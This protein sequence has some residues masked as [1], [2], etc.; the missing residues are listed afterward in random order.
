[1]KKIISIL[2]CISMLWGLCGCGERIPEA[3]YRG[4]DTEASDVELKAAVLCFEPEKTPESYIYLQQPLIF[5]LE[6]ELCDVSGREDDAASVLDGAELVYLDESLLNCPGA[7]ALFSQIEAYT[8]GGCTV[9]VPNAFFDSF[10]RG[11]LGAKSFRRIGGYPENIKLCQCGADL[12]KLGTVVTDFEQLYRQYDGFDRLASCDYGYAMAVGSAVPLVECSEGALYTMNRYG[13][14]LV[15]FTN[16]LLP[17]YYSS[18][19]LTMEKGEQTVTGF[20]ASS[21]SFNMLIYSGLGEYA[22]KQKYGY[23]L[24]KAFGYFGTPSM[25]WELHY[26]EITGIENGALYSFAELA[27]QARQIPSWTIIR[28]SYRWF[29]RT[30]GTSYLLGS[31]AEDGLHFEMDLAENAYSSGTHIAA[32]SAWLSNGCEMDETSYFSDLQLHDLRSYPALADADGDGLTDI[33]SGSKDGNIYFYKGK[34]YTD[35]LHTYEARILCDVN[36]APLNKGPYSAPCMADIDGDGDDDLIWGVLGGDLYAAVCL[37]DMTF[38]APVRLLA[39][40]EGGTGTSGQLLPQTCDLNGD[41]ALDLLLGSDDGNLILINGVP[42][43]ACAQA[44][45]ADHDH[46]EDS[47]YRDMRRDCAAAGLGSWLSPYAADIDADAEYELL[48]GTYDGYIYSFEAAYSDEAFLVLEPRGYLSC[49]EMNHKQNYNI[50]FGNYAS[51][52]IADLNGDGT[53]DLLCGNMEY[54]LAYPVDSPYFPF[55]QQLREQVAYCLDRDWY[56]GLHLFTNAGASEQRELWELGTHMDVLESEFGADLSCAGANQHTWY[57]S[58]QGESQT[59]KACRDAGLLWNSGFASAG[60]YNTA[61]QNSAENVLDLPF[62]LVDEQSGRDFLV[63]NNSVLIYGGDDRLEVS[64]RYH[65][66][67]SIFYHCDFCTSQNAGAQNA[68][69]KASAY[70]QAYGNVFNRE[71]QMMKASAAVIHQDVKACGNL[72]GGGLVLE[73]SLR[74]TD[75]GLYDE[76][77]AGSLGVRLCVSEL[78][79]IGDISTDADIWYADGEDLVIGLNRPVSLKLGNSGEKSHLAKINMA[80]SIEPGRDSTRVEFLSGGMMQAWVFGQAKTADTGWD[81]YPCGDFTVFTRFGSCE[82]LTVQFAD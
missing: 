10:S 47:G 33:I 23:A 59:L 2:I 41:G 80:A 49:S 69:D 71:D 22:A 31:S 57:V 16:N 67:V 44:W 9:F 81:V 52:R 21:A 72:L 74:S 54:G 27:E 79:D 11:F 28:N 50:K 32:G 3:E 77:A 26:E 76:A 12:E 6:T 39:G 66:P 15:F 55:R 5:G 48:V 46:D 1:M 19:S 40:G 20:A 73:S 70:Q 45:T 62:M 56:V 53:A 7:E 34:G 25:S 75:F 14:G 63:Q 43:M 58:A 64:A 82:T 36:G 24:E 29:L 8:A 61:P 38:D 35:R 51:P 18:S 37:S 65:M 60:G 4:P 13:R 17:N 30:E 68:V 42:G 78:I